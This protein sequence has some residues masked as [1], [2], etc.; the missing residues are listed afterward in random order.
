MNASRRSIISMKHLALRAQ[1]WPDVK[2]E[3]VWHRAGKKG[4]TTIPRLMP[5]FMRIMDVLSNGKP[6]SSVYFELFCRAF[7]EQLVV[8]K[9]DKEMAFFSGSTGQRAVQTWISKIKI[10]DK[11][12]F[13]KTASGPNGQYSY[14]LIMNPYKVIQRIFKKKKSGI[15]DDYYHALLARAAE[16]GADDI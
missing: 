12:G 7:D 5:L 16:I 15:L 8:L 3:D 9:N 4:F 14:V 10:L 6:V 11:L 13:I 2:E 1:L